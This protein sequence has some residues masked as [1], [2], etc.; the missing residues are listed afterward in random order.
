M[1]TEIWLDENDWTELYRTVHHKPAIPTVD[2][3]WA[4]KGYQNFVVKVRGMW[5]YAYPHEVIFIMRDPRA[6]VGD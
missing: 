5:E 2:E 3:K 6:E 4:T 1:A